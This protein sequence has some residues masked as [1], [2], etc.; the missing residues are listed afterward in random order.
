MSGPDEPKTIRDLTDAELTEALATARR[1]VE[2]TDNDYLDELSRRDTEKFA[3]IM[4]ESA[5]S[6]SKSAESASW[7]AK[8]S[9]VAAIFSAVAAIGT[10]ILNATTHPFTCVPL[11]RRQFRTP[12]RQS[13]A[14][15]CY[16]ACRSLLAAGACHQSRRSLLA[17][18]ACH[19]AC[20]P[21]L[22]G[23]CHQACRPLLAAEGDLAR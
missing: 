23:P 16:Q 18:G 20:R 11:H 5:E 19:Q 8:A 17:A 2:Y 1:K 22:A 10:L 12:Q 7:T 14:L 13:P 6:A 3:K 21:F 9:A 15:L 4:L